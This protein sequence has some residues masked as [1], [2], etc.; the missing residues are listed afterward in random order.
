MKRGFGPTISTA[1]GRRSAPR[2]NIL[3]QTPESRICATRHTCRREE[4]ASG[5]WRYKSAAMA[6]DFGVADC[7]LV[8]CGWNGYSVVQ[9]GSAGPRRASACRC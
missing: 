2:P 8:P 4:G 3:R 5:W 6:V 7:V 1:L 9:P